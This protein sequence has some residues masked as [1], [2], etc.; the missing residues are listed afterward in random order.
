MWVVLF[1][2]NGLISDQDITV[3]NLK[4]NYFEFDM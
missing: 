4:Y 2:V 1:I 3:K